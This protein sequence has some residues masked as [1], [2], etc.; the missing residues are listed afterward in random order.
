MSSPAE[1]Y[2]G[3]IRAGAWVAAG[4]VPVAVACGLWVRAKSGAVCPRWQLPRVV[5]PGPVILALFVLSLL[6]PQFL[7]RLADAGGVFD[8]LYPNGFPTLPAGSSED[9]AHSLALN[10]KVMWARVAYL[11]MLMTAAIVMSRADLWSGVREWP[12]HVTLGTLTFLTF[13]IAAFA[14]NAVVD[15]VFR[16]LGVTPDEHILSKMGRH[17][18]G[19][20]G[21]L[22]VLSACVAAPVIE[23]FLFRGLL[24]P[25]A[26][27]R[28]HRPW[29][30]MAIA[31][32]VAFYFSGL[33]LP[34]LAFVAV[35]AAGQFLVRW[36]GVRTGRAIW[37][38]AVLFAAVHSAVWPS[39]IALFVLA[40]GLGY[41]TARTRSWL[42]AA[43]A[44]GLFNL[45]STLFVFSRG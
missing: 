44:H 31:A 34:P 26:S 28:R 27:G 20:G 42:P 13:G 32:A 8:A 1:D 41:V 22:F 11:L 12:R 30:L 6:L 29:L 40:L 3:M 15:V 24:V 45:V 5:W 7:V 36:P 43:V 4:A 16:Q 39:P 14:L 17:G 18:D 25:W 38:S 33:R 37:S 21:V 23:E 9:D 19:T 10:V 2:V 35:L